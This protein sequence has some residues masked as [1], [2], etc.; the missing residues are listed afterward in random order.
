M[1]RLIRAG[2]ALFT[3]HTNAD[4]RRPRRLGCAGR[5]DRPA[6]DGRS[7][8]APRR[9]D[10]QVVVD[11]ARRPTPIGCGTR[12]SRPVPARIGDYAECSWTGRRASG[13]SGRAAR[14]RRSARSAQLERVRGPGR[15]GV[16]RGRAGAVLAA[17][18]AA[19]PY[20]EPAFDVFELRRPRSA[21]ASGRVG[22]LPEPSAARVRRAGRAGLPA[23]A[24]G[25]RAA[26]DPTRRSAPS[27]SAAA[28]ETPCSARSRPPGSTPTSPPTCATTRPTN[29]CAAGGPA[30]VDAAHWATERP[31][32]DAGR[33]VLRP[34]GAGLSR[35]AVSDL[36][37]DPWTVHAADPCGRK[38]QTVKADPSSAPPAGPAGDRHRTS[39][40][41]PT[42]A[43]HAAASWPSWSRWPGELPRLE[44]ERVRAQVAVDDLDRDIAGWR[45][46]STQVRPRKDRDREP[47]GPAPVRPSEL[48]ALQHELAR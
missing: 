31:G 2:C 21:R 26:G 27:R 32:C 19:H 38:E 12:C 45:R 25:V 14:T 40:S 5:G 29:T 13:S 15:G 35:R 23:T 7:S 43:R 44:D 4:S 20:E 10:G 9:A 34:G 16:P 36:R 8:R 28:P 37:T 47:A 41:W 3:A 22:E 33:R 17:M 1:H 30:L 48:E 24:W 42:A 39:P 18:R 6:G 11:G 46:T